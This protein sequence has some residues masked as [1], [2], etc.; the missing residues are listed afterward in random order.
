M[1]V[2]DVAYRNRAVPFAKIEWL[3]RFAWAVDCCYARSQA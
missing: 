2:D 3:R 1:L